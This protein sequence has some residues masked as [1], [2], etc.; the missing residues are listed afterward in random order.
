MTMVSAIGSSPSLLDGLAALTRVGIGR[1]SG[2]GRPATARTAAPTPFRTADRVEISPAA[3]SAAPATAAA[4]PEPSCDCNEGPDGLTDEERAQVR[5]L[6]QRDHSVRSHEH[7]HKGAGGAHAGGI[8][9][10]Y[11]TGPDGRRYAVGGEVP[12]DV[13]PVEGDPAATIRK[14]Q[15][16]RRAALAPADPS[17]ADRAVAAKAQQTAQEAQAEQSNPDAAAGR[18]AYRSAAARYG[19]PTRSRKPELIDVIA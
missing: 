19:A 8:S 5:N 14:M 2:A 13:A 16:I 12:I 17:A 15:Q 1:P 11:E 6:E 9:Y 4:A 3:A 10:S 18:G 7:A